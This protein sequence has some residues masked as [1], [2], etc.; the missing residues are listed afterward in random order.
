M[1]KSYTKYNIC[2]VTSHVISH[3]ITIF[4]IL[5][6][7]LITIIILTELSIINRFKFIT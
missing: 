6:F 1:T 3:V 5:Y 7:N 4:N 2:H